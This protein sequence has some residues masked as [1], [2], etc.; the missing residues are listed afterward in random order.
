MTER[1][2]SHAPIYNWDDDS[3]DICKPAFL[4]QLGDQEKEPKFWRRK[5]I[6]VPGTTIK[7]N[8]QVKT[9]N[10]LSSE[11]V[12]MKID[13]ERKKKEEYKK[14]AEED[15]TYYDSDYCDFE[16]DDE[17]TQT[18]SDNEHK[19]TE[20]IE[21]HDR[22]IYIG[23]L[24]TSSECSELIQATTQLGY[25]SIEHEYPKEYRSSERVLVLCKKLADMLWQRIKPYLT[26]ADFKGVRPYGFDNGGTWKPIGT[27][28]CL[29]FNR[30]K[31]NA[32]F[33]PHQDA[34]FIRNDNEQSIFTILIYLDASY[35]GTTLLKKVSDSKETNVSVM[36]FKKITSLR[37]KEGAVAIFNHD[38]Y[39]A[40]QRVRYGRKYVLRTELI[41]KR[42]DSESI[43][44]MNYKQDQEYLRIKKLVDESNELEKQG[45][46]VVKNILYLNRD[47]N[48]YARSPPL[49]KAFY[50]L[51]WA[52]LVKS[53]CVSKKNKYRYYYDDESIPDETRE[54]V[55]S[56]EN[57]LIEALESTYRGKEDQEYKDWYHAFISRANMEKFFCPVLLDFGISHYRYGLSKDSCF[58]VSRTYAGR[59]D[60]PHFYLNQYGYD[61]IVIGDRYLCTQYHCERLNI[62]TE[63]GEIEDFNLFKV[64]IYQLYKDD[65]NV[66]LKEHPLV[67]C[68]PVAWS[69][70]DKEKVKSAVFELGIPGICF[71]D[72]NKMLSLFYQ[73]PDFFGINVG[74]SGVRC[75]TVID[76]QPQNNNS[77]FHYPPVKE[78][79][80]KFLNSS[81]YY[82]ADKSYYWPHQFTE[83]ALVTP[84]DKDRNPKQYDDFA[85]NQPKINIGS[86]YAPVEISGH[87]RLELG[88]WY[89]EEI[90][91]CVEDAI[92]TIQTN[93][94]YS[95]ELRDKV[96]SNVMITG[97][98]AMIENMSERLNARITE[99]LPNLKINFTIQENVTFDSDDRG[100]VKQAR[101][102]PTDMNV[103]GGAKIFASLSNFRE[104]C[105]M[106]P[107]NN[108]C[109]I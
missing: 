32:F 4:E 13:Q 61:D 52:P 100:S 36:K 22:C 35:A 87:E 75:T 24:L 38:L 42:I 45:K 105:E 85:R 95:K 1:A 19:H 44:R 53:C 63:T 64:L 10:L 69:D 8:P 70:S 55:S 25:E 28:E 92:S 91:L 6:L 56:M 40:G 67:I 20:E 2:L 104:K 16:D 39:H 62:V 71:V 73:K 49:W 46:D 72:P 9:V 21:N 7:I 88:N 26:D 82:G 83:L 77:V 97:G 60:H 47:I 57:P 3:S 43:Y 78:K 102:G 98:G 30:Y 66:N 17:E 5:D 109:V 96:L 99:L 107:A 54:D 101:W 37:P 29:R 76:G 23:S 81:Y 18:D 31:K 51:R 103:I 84:F 89:Y 41:F 94:G 15:G 74:P 90:M 50:A 80:K 34:K 27:N 86:Y 68:T 59:P 108:E 12:Q 48:S 93:E 65:L 11:K 106:N 79:F 33:K 14:Q 58:W